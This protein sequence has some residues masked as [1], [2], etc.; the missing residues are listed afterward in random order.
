[1]QLQLAFAL[2]FIYCGNSIYHYRKRVFH[3]VPHCTDVGVII[4]LLS[5]ETLLQEKNS[6]GRRWDSNLDLVYIYFTLGKDIGICP[7]LLEN[8]P[9]NDL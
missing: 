3:I 7:T 4:W 1:M 8:F 2:Y 9:S 6:T 5:V